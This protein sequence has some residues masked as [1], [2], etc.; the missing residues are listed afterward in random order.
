MTM[1]EISH[2]VPM[3][4]ELALQKTHREVSFIADRIQSTLE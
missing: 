4:E 2:L 3:I 1:S